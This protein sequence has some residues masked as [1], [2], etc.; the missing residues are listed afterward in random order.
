MDV[1]VVG[2]GPVG[3]LLAAELKLAGADPLVIEKR[4]GP[5]GLPRARGIGPLATEALV[6]R[7]LGAELAEHDDKGRAD[8]LRDHGSAKGHFASIFKIDQ[9]AQEE[10]DRRF[11]LIWQAELEKILL[12]YA[13]GLGVEIRYGTELTELH[14]DADGVTANGLR[15]DY[16]VGCDGG[17]ST[18]RK[19]AGFEFPGTPPLMTVRRVAAQVTGELP[20]PG[21]LD[22]G[23]LYY[24][25][26][27]VATFDFDD[28]DRYDGPVTAEEMQASIKRVTGADVTVMNVGDGLRFTD[29]AR[30]VTDYRRGRVFLA[31]DAAHVH[32][33][34]GGQG[35]NLGLMDAVNLG[36][37]LANGRD[38]LLDTYHLE[39]H[40]VGAAV[41][42]NTRA[43]S[44][45]LRPGPHTDALRDI[46]SDL[47]DIPEVVRYFGRMTSGLDT[48]HELPYPMDHP[49]AGTY[50]PDLH[51]TYA[52]GRRGR[53]S[54]L[55]RT[56]GL[57][58][59]GPPDIV[60]TGRED[61]AAALIRP[62]GV[63]AWAAA[64]GDSYETLAVVRS[65]WE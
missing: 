24:G 11:T 43:Q 58:Q 22:N 18:V 20:R 6:R 15:A 12:R 41:L 17:H 37:K 23:T 27:A 33:P 21:R 45:L 13:R 61:L 44:A 38:G 59:I 56:G 19:L 35:L 51:L 63:V 3:M 25:G 7:G 42:H 8:K 30:Q 31:G 57:V 29:Q 60:S 47:M 2:A 39:R 50:C 34:S 49:L 46:I 4:D 53:L 9:D 62:D 55:T 1:I 16:L 40:P 5:S 65:T 52:D 64:P 54:D 48:R 28:H 32:S 26:G 10:P 14:Q 36:W